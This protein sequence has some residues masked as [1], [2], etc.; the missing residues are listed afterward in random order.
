MACKGKNP[1]SYAKR[2]PRSSKVLE[3][4]GIASRNNNKT[5]SLQGIFNKLLGLIKS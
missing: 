3:L 4:T 1:S 2:R 5:R